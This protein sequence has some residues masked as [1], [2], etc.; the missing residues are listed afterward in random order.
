MITTEDI[1]YARNLLS[2]KWGDEIVSK[3]EEFPSLSMAFKEFL[4]ECTA[5]GGDWGGML[6]TGIKRL[7]PEIYDAI[8]ERMGSSAFLCIVNLLILM[9]VDTN[10]E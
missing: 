4:S 3:C 10:E 9:G 2:R 8:P 5:C 1:E 7:R 6:L